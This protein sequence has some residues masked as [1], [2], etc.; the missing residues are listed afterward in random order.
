[1]ANNKNWLKEIEVQPQF[2]DLVMD[3]DCSA[4]SLPLPLSLFRDIIGLHLFAQLSNLC[5]LRFAS[6]RVENYMSSRDRYVSAMK[7]R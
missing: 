4:P 6:I 5:L 1:M 7:Y 2:I 3:I